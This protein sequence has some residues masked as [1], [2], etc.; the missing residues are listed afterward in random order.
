MKRTLTALFTALAL[1]TTTATA[2]AQSPV[3]EVGTDQD[4]DT[5]VTA[6]VTAYD[7]DDDE[8]Q[9]EFDAPLGTVVTGDLHKKIKSLITVRASFQD[10]LIKSSDDL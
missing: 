8:I 2:F 5:T 3:P 4:A 6:K 9:G 10:E 7:Y 1:L